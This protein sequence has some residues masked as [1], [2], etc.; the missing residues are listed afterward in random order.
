M[1]SVG[2]CLNCRVVAFLGHFILLQVLGAQAAYKA[3]F[4]GFLT[5]LWSFLKGP[6]CEIFPCI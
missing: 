5:V 4:V 6:L 1:R 2:L 3:T